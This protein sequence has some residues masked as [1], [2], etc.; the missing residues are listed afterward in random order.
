MKKKHKSNEFQNARLRKKFINQVKKYWGV[1]NNDRKRHHYP[2]HH[3]LV[4]KIRFK[5]YKNYQ[6]RCKAIR[7]SYI[8]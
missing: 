1:T 4:S 3:K 2:M 7:E 5:D 6:M 8:L